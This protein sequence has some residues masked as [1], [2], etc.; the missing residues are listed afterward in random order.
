MRRTA[1]PGSFAI[2]KLPRQRLLRHSFAKEADRQDD[3]VCEGV[4]ECVC[5]RALSLF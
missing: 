2:S 5:A 4:C 1:A 3:K